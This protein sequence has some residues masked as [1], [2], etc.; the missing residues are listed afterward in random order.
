[1]ELCSGTLLFGGLFLLTEPYCSPKGGLPS[2]IFGIVGGLVVM[3]LRKFGIFEDSTCFAV[4][5]M[6]ALSPLFEKYSPR[7]INIKSTVSSY[8]LTSNI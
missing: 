3:L 2:L 1:M 6:N 5:L 8:N 7:K 4:L